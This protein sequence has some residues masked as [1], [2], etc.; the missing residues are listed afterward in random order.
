MVILREEGRERCECED[1]ADR[2]GPEPNGSRRAEGFRNRDLLA[3]TLCGVL[4]PH[5]P[6]GP[7]S[8]GRPPAELSTPGPYGPGEGQALQGAGPVPDRARIIRSRTRRG[9]EARPD[10]EGEGDAGCRTRLSTPKSHRVHGF[11]AEDQGP[12]TLARGSDGQEFH[13]P[14][15]STA[16]IIR[17]SWIDLTQKLDSHAV[18]VGDDPDERWSSPGAD[19][20]GFPRLGPRSSRSLPTRDLASGSSTR[21]RPAPGPTEKSC[22]MFGVIGFS[23]CRRGPYSRGRSGLVP[24]P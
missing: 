17:T 12:W 13:W 14:S 5:E 19:L 22:T 23:S 1:E 11:A 18:Y 20:G 8:W 24:R 4:A 3:R 6:P 7:R 2:C 21:T 15:S 9:G 10:A 16:L